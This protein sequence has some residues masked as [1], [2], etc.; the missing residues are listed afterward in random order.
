MSIAQLIA[1]TKSNFTAL[2]A[3]AAGVPAFVGDRIAV[4]NA[5]GKPADV[6]V[7]VDVKK[8]NIKVESLLTN[9]SVLLGVKN[10]DANGVLLSN[11]TTAQLFKSSVLP[12]PGRKGTKKVL[13]AP[14][15]LSICTKLFLDHPDMEKSEMCKLFQSEA[16]CTRMGANTY[17]LALVK[18]HAA[19]AVTH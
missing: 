16:N 11:N 19:P 6:L 3:A 13:G 14:T 1:D 12:K 10:F 4:L 17:Y 18:K 2:P 15:K 8:R 7:V 5:K 9:E